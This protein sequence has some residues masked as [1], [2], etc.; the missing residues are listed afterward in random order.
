MPPSP[1][2]CLIGPTGCGKSDVALHLARATDGEVIACDAFTVYRDMEIL[3]ARPEPPDDV[4]HHL[5]GFLD[6]TKDRFSAAAFVEAT[7]RLVADIRARGGTPWIVGGTALYLRGWL[8]GF[9]PPVE[10]DEAY[11]AELAA[12]RELRGPEHLHGLLEARDPARAA[13]LHPN[14]TKR[15]VRALEI[16]RATGQPASAFREDWTGPDLR[17]AVVVRLRRSKEDL[18]DRIRRRTDAM[19]AAGVVDEARRLLASPLRPEGAKVLGLDVLA[20]LLAGELDETEARETIATKT[21]QFA[22]RQRTFFDSFE[23]VHVVDVGADEPT[24]SVASRVLAALRPQL[25]GTS[26]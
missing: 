17:A 16:L 23:N 26:A 1:V 19:F 3:T 21:R 7:D 20:R 4:P 15:V 14:D 18:H 6:P 25:R 11:R 9:G 12:L 13:Q 8:K 10:R 22:K 2:P 24:E 5:L